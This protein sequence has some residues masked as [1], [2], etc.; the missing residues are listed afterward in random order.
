MTLLFIRRAAARQMRAARR[1][2]VCATVGWLCLIGAAHLVSAPPT[3]AQSGNLFT[4]VVKVNGAPITG[5]DVQ[6]RARLMQLGAGDRPVPGL[7][8]RAT[9]E[10]V[11]D[12]LK[13]QEAERLGVDVSEQELLAATADIGARNNMTAEQFFDLLE[14]DGIAPATFLHQLKAD[15]AWGR[16]LRGRFA[17][18]TT[19]TDGEIDAMV[20]A[21]NVDAAA[22]APRYRMAQVLVPVGREAP[23]PQVVSAAERAAAAK[24]RISSCDDLEAVAAA[25]RGRAAVI[26]VLRLE[27]MP[28]PVRSA[29]PDLDAGGSIGPLRSPDGFHVFVLCEVVRARGMSPAEASDRVQADKMNRYSETYMQELERD[30]LIEA[31]N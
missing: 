23:R 22:A 2:A 25:V 8:E 14:N 17:D 27:Q 18:R 7:M 10:L 3:H 6:Q 20:E 24:G 31:A 19:P 16:I 11:Q 30:A 29:A 4:V 15:L 28:P 5:Y 26:G 12:A 1:L 21:S 13:L 9:Q